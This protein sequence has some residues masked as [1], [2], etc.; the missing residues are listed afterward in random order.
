MLSTEDLLVFFAAVIDALPA[1]QSPEHA[2]ISFVIDLSKLDKE[3]DIESGKVLLD[4]IRMTLQ[5]L[6]EIDEKEN[7]YKERPKGASA[8]DCIGFLYQQIKNLQRDLGLAGTL[9]T[10]MF[11]AT[12]EHLQ[13]LHGRREAADKDAYKRREE[14]TEKAREERAK[15]E[16]QNKRRE[17]RQYRD[18][19]RA[20][21]QYQHAFQD[22][23]NE[24][25]IR[26]AKETFESMFKDGGNF[27]RFYEQAFY[28]GDRTCYDTFEEL[29]RKQSKQQ[30]PPR[31]NVNPRWFEILGVEPNANR[32]RI[33]KA[34]RILAK[35]H[36]PDREGGNNEMM[37]KINAARD[38]GL[39]RFR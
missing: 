18:G 5:R 23:L 28:G 34:W 8:A 30:P 10:K 16:E 32:D 6:A 35:K 33:N 15:Y 1:N 37:S 31:P 29:R 25:T 26:K 36:H 39:A 24:E 2:T 4:S 14:A 13:E 27:H 11:Q 12:I 21:N 17:E 7:Y 19:F 22:D 3:L 20:K 9:G 38:E